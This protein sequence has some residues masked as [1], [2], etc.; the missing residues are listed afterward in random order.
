MAADPISVPRRALKPLPRHSSRIDRRILAAVFAPSLLILCVSLTACHRKHHAKP[1]AASAAPALTPAQIDE[2]SC[3]AFVQNFYDWYWNPYAESANSVA[4]DTHKLPN[5]DAVLKH[6]PPVLSAELSKLLADEEK[7]N[8]ATHSV[9]NL[10]FDPFWGNQDAQG[11]YI[12]RRV[13]V[14]GDSC[15]VSIPQGDV[16][17]ELKRTGQSWVFVNFDY[18]FAALDS[19]KG[20]TCPDTDL[21]KILKP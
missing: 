2:Q 1:G 17:A 6:K 11:K 3:R 15:K 21:V 12:A 20:R 9:G 13:L 7:K 19:T 4:F 14:T 18:C 8:Q 5:V 16:I 10:D